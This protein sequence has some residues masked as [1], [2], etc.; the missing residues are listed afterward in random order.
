MQKSR[1]VDGGRG[2]NE[3]R[4]RQTA[5]GGAEHLLIPPPPWLPSW[6]GSWIIRPYSA[7]SSE[8]VGPENSFGFWPRSCQSGRYAQQR[9]EMWCSRRFR[10]SR[11][12]SLTA[13]PTL[14]SRTMP[15]SS[16]AAPVREHQFAIP[17]SG[18]KGGIPAGT[19]GSTTDRSALQAYQKWSKGGLWVP[20][21]RWRGS[22]G[23][24]RRAWSVIEAI[25]SAARGT[26]G[27][28][29]I[30]SGVRSAILHHS[31]SN[32]AVPTLRMT[33]AC[34]VSLLLVRASAAWSASFA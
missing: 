16:M 25:R 13:F 10:R 33:G 24:R 27:T 6:D 20:W 15:L 18:A 4:W 29:G 34:P 2:V 3:G 21:R 32:E 17:G 7:I 8:V 31:S 9:I 22:R 12:S 30:H 11:N 19:A 23:P 28:T 26:Y 1:G 5:L 14:N